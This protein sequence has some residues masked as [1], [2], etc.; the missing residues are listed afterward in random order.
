[1]IKKLKPYMMK[2][3]KPLI[4]TPFFIIGEIILE[5]Y[6]PY[7]MA[8]I[9]DV[10]IASQDVTYVTRMGALMVGIAI[11]ALIFGVAASIT[12]AN[13]SMGFASEVRKAIFNKIQNFSFSN[14][15]KFSTASLVTRSTSDITNVQNAYM[16]FLRVFF[17]G[18][19][20]LIAAMIMAFRINQRLVMIF[21]VVLP[22]LGFILAFIHR[23][24]HPRF[25]KLMRAY[26]RVNS[27]VQENLIAIRVVKSFVR[28]KFEKL[29]FKK[30]NENHMNSSIYAQKLIV[31]L[32]P[33]MQLI[34]YA[35]TICILW[36][37]GRMII[38]GE[39]LTGELI[40]FISYIA[41]ILMSL[42]MISMVFMMW[43][44]SRASIQRIIEILDE[45]PEIT[46]DNADMELTLND[47]SI[48]FDHVNFKYKTDAE[49]N[50]LEDIS[51]RIESGQTVGIIGG[52][53]SG[54]TTLVQLIPRLYEATEGDIFVGGNNIKAYSLDHLRDAVSMVL[55]QNTLFTGTIKD[56]LKW[57][58]LTATDE[59]IIAASKDAQ[60]HEF[61]MSFPD[62]Y[63][64]ILGQGG[65]NVS[66][67]QKQRLCIARA[68]LNEP[69]ILILDDSTSA[70]DTATEAHIREAFRE[71]LQD[72]TKL[73][74][75]QRITSV[76]D[77]DMIIVMDEGQI[78]AIGT[79]EELLKNNK[80]YQEVYYS[81][82]EGVA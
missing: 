11:L 75:A 42:M 20:M 78:D 76:C 27:T 31:F 40:S 59:E 41:Q 13:A 82:Q 22:I 14:I 50:I 48:I 73:I 9:V 74:I 79:H 37:G 35:T 53:G 62:G 12:S 17:R 2:Y 61:I 6:L 58:K 71:N 5:I 26:D 65:V 15:D 24:A 21:F 55:Q 36:F 18:P 77:A 47:G 34:M 80:I 1:M 46:D 29:K 69:K 25:L 54:K 64:T 45:E 30:S 52:T 7:L 60:A 4:L 51:F 63:D 39:M 49:S 8:K 38:V 33:A 32:M 3:K 68:L 10:G 67:G 43:I 16:T 23:T 70:V 56:N 81:Q 57:G 66:G 72:T 44:M 28:S 19:V